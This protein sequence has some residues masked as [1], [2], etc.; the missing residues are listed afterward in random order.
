SLPPTIPRG[1]PASGSRRRAA[2]DN[3]ARSGVGIMSEGYVRCKS[4]P[5]S[6]PAIIETSR[7]S[8]FVPDSCTAANDVLTNLLYQP[9]ISG[10][11]AAVIIFFDLAMWAFT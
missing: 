11:F 4:A 8:H 6:R 5:H 1:S 10:T 3:T 2:T 9:P 7:Q